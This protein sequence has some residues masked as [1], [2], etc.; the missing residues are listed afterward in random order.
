MI[1]ESCLAW[2]VR[3]W[4]GSAIVMVNLIPLLAAGRRQLA[5]KRYSGCRE[6]T[7]ENFRLGIRRR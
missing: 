7:L 1:R 4:L 3:R 2:Q 6:Y 5:L